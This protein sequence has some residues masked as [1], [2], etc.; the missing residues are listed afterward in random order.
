MKID[1][2]LK[3]F[4]GGVGTI[5]SLKQNLRKEII[6]LRQGLWLFISFDL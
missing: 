3:T 5:I 4:L 6:V 1:Y 2:D